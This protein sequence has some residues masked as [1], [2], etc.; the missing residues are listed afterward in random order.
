M[1]EMDRHVMTANIALTR[2][3]ADKNQSN[4]VANI[5]YNT[6]T[7]IMLMCEVVNKVNPLDVLRAS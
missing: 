5:A 3:R 2:L 6:F 4:L 7:E 1:S